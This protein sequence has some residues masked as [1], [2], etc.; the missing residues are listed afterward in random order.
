[1]SE[2]RA[3][4]ERRRPGRRTWI[5][6][7]VVVVVAALAAWGIALAAGGGRS[8][9]P[10]DP[11]STS[12]TP[13]PSATGSPVP[14]PSLSQTP[15]PTPSVNPSDPSDPVASEPA[16]R[17]TLPPAPLEQ[18]VAPVGG[19]EVELTSI[20]SV[21]GI[22]AVAG[23]VGGPALRITVEATNDGAAAVDTPAAIV[24]LYVGGDRR[25]ANA[26][27]QP[28]GRSFPPSI[29]ARGSATGVYLFTVP[30]EER[31]AIV[32]EVDLLFGAPVVLFSGA[33]R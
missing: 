14:L 11:A 31:D 5:T 10:V 9:A 33:V 15:A 2:E 16:A 30:V 28:G 32:V 4:S 23:E 29:P 24:N 13:S 22:A 7:V 27:M 17:E 12:A 3:A 19:L 6:V 26:I 18:A 25:P 8:P 1:M 21:E 20:E